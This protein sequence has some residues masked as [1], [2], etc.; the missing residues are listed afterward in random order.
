M[1]MV[2]YRDKPSL[3]VEKAMP[4]DEMAHYTM[5]S[6]WWRSCSGLLLP[7]QASSVVREIKAGLLAP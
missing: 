1:D 5:Y 2:D 6:C 7:A 3:Y 4:P